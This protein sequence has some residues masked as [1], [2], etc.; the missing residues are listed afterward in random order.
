MMAAVCKVK[1]AQNQDPG[2]HHCIL[3]CSAPQNIPR[4]G[5][6][7]SLGYQLN[8][9]PSIDSDHTLLNCLVVLTLFKPMA[10]LPHLRIKALSEEHFLS[11]FC[12][13]ALGLIPSTHMV[14]HYHLLLQSQGI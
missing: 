11:Y 3:S 14:A 4:E 10:L 2:F 8:R 1:M 5:S 13:V 9:L 12:F 6:Q 7:V